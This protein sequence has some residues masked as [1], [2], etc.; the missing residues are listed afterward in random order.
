M[1]TIKVR[2]RNA[3]KTIHEYR[4]VDINSERILRIFISNER[5]S[6]CILYEQLSFLW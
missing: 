2:I 3:W 4:T 6:I 5:Q 1:Q